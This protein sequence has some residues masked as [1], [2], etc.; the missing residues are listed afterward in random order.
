MLNENSS[1]IIKAAEVI[2]LTSGE[3]VEVLTLINDLVLV[4]AVQA[5]SVYSTKEK[6]EDP[7]GNGL[8][9]SV[10]L[11]GDAQL[12]S[13]DGDF[14]AMHKAGVIGLN[15]DKVILVTPNDIQ[16]FADRGDALRNQNEL[17]RISLA[18]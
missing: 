3:K 10:L 16:L 4:L 18:E 11:E 9:H 12:L 8:L 17:A 5:L 13:K 1:N 15:D 6:I 2:T 14:M 7:L